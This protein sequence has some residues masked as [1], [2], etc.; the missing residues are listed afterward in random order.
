MTDLTNTAPVAVI[1]PG[2]SED[3]RRLIKLDDDIAKIRT[4]IATAD[5]ARQRGQR[6]IDPDW[7][8]R[9]RTALRHLCRERSELLAK[10][11]SDVAHAL[12]PV[13][14]TAWCSTSQAMC[15]ATGRSIWYAPNDPVRVAGARHR[16]RS[17]QNVT[18]SSRLLPASVRTA[19]LSFQCG[20]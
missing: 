8:H 2:M 3:Q 20:R 10:G 17:A 1:S 13:K 18:A 4:Q 12:R 19:A 6:P 9:A 11:W 7:F 5:L 15:G 14:K 16:P